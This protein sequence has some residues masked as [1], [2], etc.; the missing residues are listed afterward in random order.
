M[1]QILA[2][3]AVRA[4]SILAVA[5]FAGLLVEAS[6]AADWPGF[7]GPTQSGAAASRSSLGELTPDSIDWQVDLPGRGLS[8][9]IVAGEKV[10]VSASGGP[11]QDRLHVLCLAAATG[12]RVWERQFW[13][14][15]R[16]MCHAKTSVAAP[17]PCTD[18]TRVCVLFSSND[19]VCLDVDGR[20][21]WLRGITADYPNVS[22]SLGMASSPAIV[23]DVVVIQVENDSESYAL[24]VD[25]K[26]GSNR[27]R[28]ERP[29]AANWTSPLALGDGL[30]A[31]QSKDGLEAVRAAD[32]QKIWTYGGGASTIPSGCRSGTLVFVPS[33]G[34]TALDAAMIT[35]G[36]PLQRW[37]TSRLSP[38]T[39]SPV[40]AGDVVYAI[41]K[42]DVLTACRVADGERLWQLRLKGPFTATPVI[43]GDDIV[44]VNEEGLIQVVRGSAE[45]GEVV[46][47]L[48]LEDQ[49]LAS[50][51]VA[52]GGIYFRSN[53][54]LWRLRCP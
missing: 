15:G 31:L 54:R 5:F 8:G 43:C 48:D 49:I 51:A 29:K 6:F 23:D 26:T 12:E 41:S 3:A 34:V 33:H 35:S 4:R 11:D 53:A 42:G 22:N 7:Q 18:G 20:L 37:R 28:V 47:T 2:G 27:W 44:C 10:F 24:G 19:L 50:P 13:A 52:A 32:G 36:Q 14:T 46:G 38:G 45:S 1:I 21:L 30:V 39:S 9:V 17:T 25:L 40:V 16:T